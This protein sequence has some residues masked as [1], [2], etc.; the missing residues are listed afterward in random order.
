MGACVVRERRTG[1]QCFLVRIYYFVVRVSLVFHCKRPMNSR[2]KKK[3]TERQAARILYRFVK[4]LSICN[5]MVSSHIF[6]WAPAMVG[7][8]PDLVVLRF[9]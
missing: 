1:L 6:G 5:W 3:T 7:V 9:Q 8:A 4:G 2:R